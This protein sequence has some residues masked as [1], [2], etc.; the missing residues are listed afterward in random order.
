MLLLT[1]FGREEVLHQLGGHGAEQGGPSQVMPSPAI[2]AVLAKPVTPSTLLDACAAA[3]GQASAAPARVSQREDALQAHHQRL[4]G[5]RVLLVEDNLI[6]QELALE[7]LGETGMVITVA[8]DGR[9]AL[10]AL[11]VL[12]SRSFDAVLMDVQ[13]PVMDGYEATRALRADPRWKDLPVIAM[14]ANAMLGDREKALAAGMD[15]HV[16]KPVDVDKLFATLL[17]WLKRG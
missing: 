5:K 3:L 11:D 16:P 13:M 14:T 4:R 2:A 7:L 12:A 17:R 15:D 8:D 9:Q 6:N 10:A 1:A